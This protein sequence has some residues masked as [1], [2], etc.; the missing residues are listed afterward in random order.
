MATMARTKFGLPVLQR[1]NLKGFSLYT[2]KSEVDVEVFDG[3]SC[4]VGANGLGKSTFIAAINFG[5]CGRVPE[6]DETFRSSGEYF[7]AIRPFSSA[8]FE[9]RISE[10]DRTTAEIELAFTVGE[11]QYHIIR[12]AFE[13]DELRFATL[14]GKDLGG[15]SEI[16]TQQLN[17]RYKSAVAKSVGVY[18]FEQ[19]VFLQLF[20]FTFDERRHLTFWQAPVQRQILLLA[21]GDDVAKAQE[22]E[23]LRRRTERL[24]SNARNANYQA[25]ETKKRLQNAQRILN[26]LGPETT[27]LLTENEE[28]YQELNSLIGKVSEARASLDDSELRTSELRSRALGLKDRIDDVFIRDGARTPNLLSRTIIAD[29][30]ASNLCQLCGASGT[31]VSSGINRQLSEPRCPLCS[32]D[33]P[34]ESGPDE[35]MREIERLDKELTEL[36]QQILE[37]ATKQHRIRAEVHD[38]QTDIDEKQRLINLFEHEHRQLPES[39]GTVDVSD[40]QQTIVSSQ[41]VIQELEKARD[42]Y[43]RQRDEAA[44]N[45]AKIQS[46]VSEQ[47][48][49]DERVFLR[50]FKDLAEAFIG[51]DLDVRFD[52]RRNDMTLVLDIAGQSRRQ[53]YQ[54]SESQRFFVDIALRMAITTFIAANGTGTLLIDTPEGSLDI[55]YESRAGQMFAQFVAQ[56][57][58]ILMTANINTSQLLRELAVRCGNEKMRIERMTEWTTLSDVQ[59][60]AQ[61]LFDQAY[62][63][64]ETDLNLAAS[65]GANN[66]T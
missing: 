11:D 13:P 60:E 49:Q 65:Q 24:D 23:N 32:V 2:K 16:N 50:A 17:E 18:S 59:A 64:I 41:R 44:Q 43:R 29:S 57:Y 7:Q 31:E 61:Y 48:A 39:I 55:A 63:Q 47:Y 36:N 33:L 19:F 38:I 5:L 28:R 34:K 45:L 4:V 9:G 6:P 66:A 35:A 8:F 21:F 10:S 52:A 26:T 46:R 62:Q 14:N 12:G 22:A 56:G 54:L 53:P 42:D 30:L 51:L 1:I 3:V 37:E 27:D 40:L 25:T 20:I 15:S 58:H